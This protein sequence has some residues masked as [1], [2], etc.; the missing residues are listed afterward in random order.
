PEIPMT[1]MWVVLTSVPLSI[2]GSWYAVAATR[3]PAARTRC[4]PVQLTSTGSRSWVRVPTTQHGCAA[5]LS[6][7]LAALRTGARPRPGRVEYLITPPPGRSRRAAHA[8]PRTA[9]PR[10]PDPAPPGPARRTPHAGPLTPDPSRRAA[11]AGP[12]TL[13]PAPPGPS[14][15]RPGQPLE[16]QR[17]SPSSSFG[18]GEHIDHCFHC[19]GG[20]PVGR[21]FHRRRPLFQQPWPVQGDRHIGPV[22][23][24]LVGDQPHIGIGLLLQRNDLQAGVLGSCHEGVP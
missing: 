4:S 22:A 9:G 1:T 3:Y 6:T 11:H 14:A 2:M 5:Q 10:T 16:V 13:G 21:Q 24:A 18:T 19:A 23:V 17:H 12:R 7:G 15:A 20:V 8:R